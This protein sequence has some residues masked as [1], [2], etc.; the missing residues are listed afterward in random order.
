ML[1]A[2]GI[3]AVVDP[4]ASA[5]FPRCWFLELTGWFC[6][7]CGGQRAA[8]D[9]LNGHVLDAMGHNALA[10]V[11]VPA[12]L[13]WLGLRTVAP[14]RAFALAGHIPPV[15]YRVIPVAVVLFWVLRNVPVAPFSVLA[16]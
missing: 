12:A 8:H 1:A 15:A 14:D 13:A 2:G 10:V 6:P 16:P 5:F 3:L 9:A 7:G 4:T 11:A